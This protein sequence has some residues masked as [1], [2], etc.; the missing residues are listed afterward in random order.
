MN[1]TEKQTITGPEAAA[2]YIDA[3]AEADL[4]FHF[5][6]D[7]ADCLSAH[8]LSDEQIEAISHN[9]DQLFKVDWEALGYE[10]PFDYMIRQHP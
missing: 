9:V 10:C 6:D 2:T 1:P 3:L 7:P 5:D 4:L 8:N